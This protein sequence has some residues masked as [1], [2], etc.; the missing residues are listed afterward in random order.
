[1]LADPSIAAGAEHI[2]VADVPI[3]LFSGNES[4]ANGDGFETWFHLLNAKHSASSVVDGFR[5]WNNG[6]K[7]M[8]TPYTN[9]LVVKNSLLTGYVNKP[10]S[11]G[12]GGNEVTRNVTY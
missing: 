4:F 2:A 5:A 3:R 10:G 11:T 12:I 8:F 7:A 1:N 9:R 6:G